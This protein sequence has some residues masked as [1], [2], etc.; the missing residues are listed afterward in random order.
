M[1]RRWFELE[2]V[3][4]ERERRLRRRFHGLGAGIVLLAVAMIAAIFVARSP[5]PVFFVVPVI[6]AMVAWTGVT[7]SR[8]G[9][10]HARARRN[11]REGGY[12]CCPQCGY[13]LRTLADDGACP[14]CGSAYTPLSLQQ[15]WEHAYRRMLDKPGR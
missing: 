13:D 7:S 10:L 4:S 12:K 3:A 15:H 8:L 9:D 14:E 2:P 5:K 6:M 11:L 1:K